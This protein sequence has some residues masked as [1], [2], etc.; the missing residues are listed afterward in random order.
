MAFKE[1]LEDVTA[2]WQSGLKGCF[3]FLGKELPIRFWFKIAKSCLD[4]DPVVL[5]RS[6][7]ISPMY[8]HH[9]KVSNIKGD[10][11]PTLVP[12]KPEIACKNGTFWFWLLKNFLKANKRSRVLNH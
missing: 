11:G 1:L 10:L 8:I 5:S 2:K 12:W 4:L 6:Y 7:C 9:C 3:T